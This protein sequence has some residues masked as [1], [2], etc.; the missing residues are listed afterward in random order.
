MCFLLTNYSLSSHTSRPLHTQDFVRL[1]SDGYK[2]IDLHLGMSRGHVNTLYKVFFI[3]LRESQRL[4]NLS[5][6]PT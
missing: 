6:V 1:Y 2:V 3:C 5:E 4:G